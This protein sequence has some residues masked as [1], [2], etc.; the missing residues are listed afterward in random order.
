[1]T[2]ISHHT[3]TSVARD[4]GKEEKITDQTVQAITSEPDVGIGSIEHLHIVSRHDGLPPYDEAQKHI[5]GYDAELM[6]ARVTLSA[7]EEQKLL[8]RIDWHLL[9]LLAVMYMVKTIDASN[10]SPHSQRK[11]SFRASHSMPGLQCSNHG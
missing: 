9:P 8:R 11:M 5:A 7:E 6:A 10:V 1:M 3:E 4:P 2:S